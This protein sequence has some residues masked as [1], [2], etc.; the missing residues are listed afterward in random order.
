MAVGSA[1]PTFRRHWTL[2][3]GPAADRAPLLHNSVEARDKAPRFLKGLELVLEF[4]TRIVERCY[5]RVL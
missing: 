4:R 1:C 2:F 5:G 3:F